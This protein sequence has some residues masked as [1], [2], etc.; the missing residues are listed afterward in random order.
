MR[1]IRVIVFVAVLLGVFSA[2]A[3]EIKEVKSPN[4]IKAWLVEDHKLPLVSMQFAFRGGV[5]QDPISKQ[6]LATLT[7]D[8]LDEGAGPYD[9][10]AFQQQLSDHSVQLKFEASRDALM[11]SI[12][13]LSQDRDTAFDLLHLALTQPRFDADAIER[14]RSQQLTSLRML[15]GNP[16]WQARHALYQYI[17]GKHPYGERHLGTIQT[18]AGLTQADIKNFAAAHLAQGNLVIAAAGDISPRE[19]APLLD[20][21]FGGLPK[22]P[23]LVPITDFVWPQ[24]AAVI[25][26]PREGT[27]T[28]LLF[29]MPGPKRSDKDWYA[30]EIANYILGGGGFSS[31]LMQD[32]R[33]KKGLTYGIN[34]GLSPMEHGGVI[35]GEAATDNPKT[36]QAW[37]IAQDTMR[38]FYDEGVNEKEVEAAK[39]YLTG[40]LPLAMTSTDKIASVLTDIQLEHL[41]RDYLANRN[42]LLRQVSVDDVN[43]AIHRW[44]NPDGLTLTMVGKPEG[45]VPTQ[46]QDLTR[47]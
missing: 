14:Q 34:T 18:L 39:D 2:Q 5:E 4:G 35:L 42:D 22:R 33:D 25:L 27:Q 1:Y 19:L 8:L 12:K 37:D 21:V 20:K 41:G 44:F 46:T 10:A 9:A 17:F 23:K 15:F 3:T 24:Q 43:Q 45:I 29:A 13:T 28:N 47:N 38:R 30:A 31:H 11:G 26:L 7:M 32:V 6:G 16:E 40:A 36:A